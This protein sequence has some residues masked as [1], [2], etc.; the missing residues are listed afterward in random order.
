MKSNPAV[1]L[2]LNENVEYKNPSSP[3]LHG[4]TKNRCQQHLGE[5]NSILRDIFH[6]SMHFASTG[7]QW[8]QFP[9]VIFSFSSI[10]LFTLN[11]MCH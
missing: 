4:I 7:Q 1:Q 5:L 8:Y 3:V 10:H 9:G 2:G 6:C 11:T